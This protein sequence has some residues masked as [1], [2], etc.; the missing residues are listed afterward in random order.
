MPAGRRGQ[1]GNAAS[2]PQHAET[3]SGLHK[4]FVIFLTGLTYC[5][6]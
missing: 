6:L 2:R 1:G 5:P 3:T 4:A